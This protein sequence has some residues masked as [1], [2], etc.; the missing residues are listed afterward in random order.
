MVLAPVLIQ[1][2]FTAAGLPLVGG[3]LYSYIAGTTTPQATYTDET[4]LTPNTNPVV[5]DS[6][7]SAEVWLNPALAYKFILRDSAGN[8]QFTVDDVMA[9]GGGGGGGFTPTKYS[10]TAGQSATPLSGQLF[11]ST[12]D[13]SILM[14][15]EVLRGTTI[16]SNTTLALQWNAGTALWQVFEGGAISNGSLHGVTWSMSTVGTQGQLNA[17]VNAGS[18][19]TIKLVQAVLYGV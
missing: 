18:N 1:R 14:F 19:G 12:I 2:F 4:G 8:L 11:D 5:L 16:I 15:L 13:T 9:S 7:G 3:L 10:I 17:A 6:T